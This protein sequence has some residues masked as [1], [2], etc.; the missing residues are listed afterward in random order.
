MHRSSKENPSKLN[1]KKHPPNRLLTTTDALLIC[2]IPKRK[3]ELL[4]K[5]YH[6]IKL[7]PKS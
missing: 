7:H 6:D 3:T 1:H 4:C 5:F 2:S